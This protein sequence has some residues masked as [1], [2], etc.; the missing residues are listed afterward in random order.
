MFIFAIN[1]LYFNE[2]VRQVHLSYTYSE[3][4]HFRGIALR[5][6]NF[7][8]NSEVVASYFHNYVILAGPRFELHSR[9]RD[10]L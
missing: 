3:G 8:C 7:F 4:G 6:H 9:R 5:Q 1:L 2:R 10:K